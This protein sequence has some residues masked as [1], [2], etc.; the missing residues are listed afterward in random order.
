MGNMEDD[1]RQNFKRRLL[2]LAISLV[3][4]RPEC[5]SDA[6]SDVNSGSNDGDQTAEDQQLRSRPIG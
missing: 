3:T 5:A 1:C 6:D 2:G 4:A